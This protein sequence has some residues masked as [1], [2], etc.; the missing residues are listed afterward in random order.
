ALVTDGMGEVISNIANG[1]SRIFPVGNNNYTP[2]TIQND[3][4]SDQFSVQCLAKV[5]ENGINGSAFGTNLVNTTWRIEEATA[6]GTDATLTAQWTSTDELAGFDRNNAFLSRYD[7]IDWDMDATMSASGSDPYTITRSNV[8]EFSP[9][10]VGTAFEGGLD[11]FGSDLV[12]TNETLV[13]GT[14]S[15]QQSIESTNLIE[16][17]STVN[18]IAANVIELKAGF[19]AESGSIF[20]AVIEDCALT[21]AD[22]ETIEQR[23]DRVTESMERTRLPL[24]FPN[25]VG[26]QL[27]IRDGIGQ[28]VVYNMLGQ[29]IQTFEIIDD[30]H[31]L[32]VSGWVSGQYVLLILRKSGERVTLSFVK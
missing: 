28:A 23:T 5:L 10:A 13:S 24:L 26:Q 20:S 15:T 27:N 31:T 14:Y 3:G 25:P 2:I 4:T 16:A 12:L 21:T 30:L 29:E 19:H 11:C 8:T 6:G 32:D 22:D 9:F 7:G 1:A 18:F 17:S